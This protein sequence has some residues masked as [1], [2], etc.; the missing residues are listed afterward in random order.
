MERDERIATLRETAPDDFTFL[1][2][3]GSSIEFETLVFVAP[4]GQEIRIPVD[5][6]WDT[7]D[8]AQEYSCL[9]ITAWDELDDLAEEYPG[10]IYPKAA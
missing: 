10:L 8:V 7:D 6:A 2:F 9:A 5:P 1:G 4:S 3:G